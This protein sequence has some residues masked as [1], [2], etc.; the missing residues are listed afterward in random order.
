MLPMF[1][2]E[3]ENADQPERS[4]S[5]VDL[6]HNMSDSPKKEIIKSLSPE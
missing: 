5:A 1:V 3:D 6:T 4:H 2:K